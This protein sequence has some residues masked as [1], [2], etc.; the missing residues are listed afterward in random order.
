VTLVVAYRALKLGY[1]KALFIL[2]DCQSTSFGSD[3]VQLGHVEHAYIE[4]WFIAKQSMSFEGT[5]ISREMTVYGW[6]HN[7]LEHDC[8]KAMTVRHRHTHTC[9]YQNT[10]PAVISRTSFA[11]STGKLTAKKPSTDDCHRL[12]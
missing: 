8:W 2:H 10:E 3:Q 9:T 11:E 6:E 1:I 5:L 7:Q 12:G 4:V